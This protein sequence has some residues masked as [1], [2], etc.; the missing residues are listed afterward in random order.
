MIESLADVQSF[1]C[2][3]TGC[4]ARVIYVPARIPAIFKGQAAL[5][6]SCPRKKHIYLACDNP[7][8]PHE[9]PYEVI[10]NASFAGE[11]DGRATG[12]SGGA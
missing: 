1:P 6:S 2:K 7:R 4:R 8:E 12:E 10:V 3:Q 5:N 9:F 11:W